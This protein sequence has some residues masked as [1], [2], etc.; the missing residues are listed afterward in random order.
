MPS[1]SLQVCSSET[2]TLHM[3]AQCT[4]AHKRRRRVLLNKPQTSLFLRGFGKN[5]KKRFENSHHTDL[6]GSDGWCWTLASSHATSQIRRYAVP[7]AAARFHTWRAAGKELLQT[8][9]L[10][11]R[12]HMRTEMTLRAN[13]TRLVLVK[14]E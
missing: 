4:L 12:L 5:T 10:L 2:D 13:T 8:L 9:V 11:A 3:R 14:F 6:Y 1:K 7:L